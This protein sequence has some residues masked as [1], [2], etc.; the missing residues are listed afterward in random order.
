MDFKTLSKRISIFVNYVVAALTACL[1]QFSG[2]SRESRQA[3]YDP[4]TAILILLD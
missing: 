2:A 3:K 1:K 4:R